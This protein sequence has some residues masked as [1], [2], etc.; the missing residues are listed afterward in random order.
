MKKS[1][2]KKVVFLTLWL[3]Y[4]VFY[5]G[6]LQIATKY[7]PLAIQF[8]EGRNISL[9][10]LLLA[11][12]NQSLGNTSYKLK[13][14]PETNNSFLIPGPLWLLQLSLS[15]TFEPKLHVTQ[16]NIL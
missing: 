16:S 5:S 13:H 14:L 3:S 6:S 11:N 8:H 4:Y 2:K 12:L 15:A 9:A 1:P 7:V 10:N